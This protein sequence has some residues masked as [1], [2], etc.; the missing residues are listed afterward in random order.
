MGGG[1]TGITLARELSK[2]PF[3]EIDLIEKS[4]ALGGFHRN[5]IIDDLQYDIGTFTFHERHNT[6]SNR[7]KMISRY[8]Q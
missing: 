4:S 2:S 5:F 8:G 1:V 6:K 7:Q 3:L